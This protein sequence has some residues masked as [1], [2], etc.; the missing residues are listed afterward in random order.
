MSTTIAVGEF[1]AKCLALFERVRAKKE[2]LLITKRGKPI[3]EV[4]PLGSSPENGIKKELAGT[5]L[6]ENDIVSPL[7]EPWEA[8]K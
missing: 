1:K 8:L 5:L 6:F 4:I 2:R 7:D 3:A